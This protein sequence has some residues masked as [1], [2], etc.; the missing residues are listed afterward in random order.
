MTPGVTRRTPRPLC[1]P[2]DEADDPHTVSADQTPLRTATV[3]LTRTLRRSH[4]PTLA[5]SAVLVLAPV[6]ALADDQHATQHAPSRGHRAPSGPVA[7]QTPSHIG[8]P[9]E[10]PTA[11]PIAD[12]AEPASE[13][14]VIPANVAH[15][16]GLQARLDALVSAITAAEAAGELRR[17]ALADARS[18]L[19]DARADQARATVSLTLSASR[20]VEASSS[21][22]QAALSDASTGL[23][24]SLVP[25]WMSL[26]GSGTEELT[27]EQQRRA[28]DAGA[29]TGVGRRL[30]ELE[31]LAATDDDAFAD[32]GTRLVEAEH[33]YRSTRATA[34]ALRQ[35]AQRLAD[36]EDRASAMA[37]TA[38]A[39]A[40]T[41]TALPA[42][43]DAK[44]AD[45]ESLVRDE[46]DALYAAAV[47]LSPAFADGRSA[48][49]FVLPGTGDISSP[50]GMRFHPVLKYVK[51][52]T[53]TDFG[54][55]DGYVYAVADGTVDSVAVNTAYG[56]LTILRHSRLGGQR[57]ETWYAHQSMPLV[58]PG[59]RVRAGQVIG[60]VGSTGYSTGPHI[61]LEVR[62]DGEP[63]DPAAFLAGA[64]HPVHVPP[65]AGPDG[66]APRR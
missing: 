12:E 54:V 39:A 19:A 9:A 59:Q 17:T 57:F 24:D 47:D 36:A 13:E 8:A 5:I 45:L 55:G 66:H 31:D 38:A 53:G 28:S 15:A 20:A 44:V 63:I 1:A 62:I 51:L 42:T 34:R 27:A 52:H 18:E 6:P 21:L 2:L 11:A 22:R 50:F 58:E 16:L 3:N 25:D 33:T 37:G 30:G 65:A 35:H 7:N 29:L 26:V 64:P 48:A 56:N 46:L 49:R 23:V 61:H 4:L 14:P 10:D 41:D 40:T 43:L 60:L 32:A